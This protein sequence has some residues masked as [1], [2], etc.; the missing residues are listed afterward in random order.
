MTE[1][2]VA[3][4]NSI[5]K[6]AV[7]NL[8]NELTHYNGVLLVNRSESELKEII[9]NKFNKICKHYLSIGQNELELLEREACEISEVAYLIHYRLPNFFK[10]IMLIHRDVLLQLQIGKHKYLEGLVSKKLLDI[11]SGESQKILLEAVAFF[12]QKFKEEEIL[13][14]RLSQRKKGIE[15]KV[16]HHQNPWTTYAKQFEI[17][18][19]QFD[20]INKNDSIVDQSIR[21]FKELSNSTNEITAVSVAESE[22]IVKELKLSISNIEKIVGKED[23][24]HIIHALEKIEASLDTPKNYQENFTQSIANTSNN[25]S[26]TNISVA[27]E[28]GLLLEKRVDFGK[29]AKK[30]MDFNILPEVIAL[31]DYKGDLIA[32]AKHSI[33]N[34]KGS[35][36]VAK[37]QENISG[38]TIDS[39]LFK[40]VEETFDTNLKAQKKLSDTISNKLKTE[41]LA[42][43]I[44]HHEEF[45][46]V[47]LQS[48]LSQYTSETNDRFTNW[49]GRL[50]GFFGNVNTAYDKV[51]SVKPSDVLDAATE[52]IAHRMFKEENAQYDMLFLNKSF[53][54]D[55]FLT[56]RTNEEIIFDKCLSHWDQGFHKSILIVGDEH[57]GKST[58]INKAVKNRLRKEV[59]VL[60][61]DSTISY[62]GRKFNT[63]KNI[64]EALQEIKK[65][66]FNSKPIVIID[67]LEFWIDKAHSFLDNV[68][69]TLKFIESESDDIL[70]IISVSKLMQLHLNHR[71]SFSNSFSTLIDVSISSNTEIFNAV[72]LRHGASHRILVDENDEHVSPRQFERLVH[73]L[74]KKFDNNLGEVLQAWTYGTNLTTDNKVVYVES[75]H[76]LPDFFTKEEAII[77]K[78]VLLYRMIDERTIKTFLGKRYD[79][80]YESGLKRLANTKVL[81]RN[82]KGYLS[83]NAVVSHEVQKSLIYRGI[84]K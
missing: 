55:H 68:R 24:N 28:G 81:V 64:K 69:A 19:D 10:D 32:F 59:I 83:L 31:W 2:E 52:C 37:N 41:F 50:K 1:N 40:S 38:S 42:T 8:M 34:L 12:I 70:L 79:A 49:I 30:W 27:T 77:L 13:A 67:D 54:G 15:S 26:R 74:C 47:S 56:F 29:S 80:G 58:F 57:S 73:R 5:L 35:L 7:H 25:L 6:Q 82:E 39:Q 53:L 75:S 72:R 65:S 4:P 36:V 21:V 78:Y 43:S 20:S 63:T 60:A 23:V 14:E 3:S 44:Y 51:V 18:L 76:Y 22:T 48:S 66:R 62:Q 17:L 71:I 16:R 61:P 9:N 46:E 84:F 33:L 45:L 11:H